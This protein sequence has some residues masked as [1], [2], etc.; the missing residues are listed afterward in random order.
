MID[1]GSLKNTQRSAKQSNSY[2][3]SRGHSVKKSSH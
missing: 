3:N 2:G 1:H